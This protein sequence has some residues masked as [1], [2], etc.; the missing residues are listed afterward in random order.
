MLVLYLCVLILFS[1]H[2]LSLNLILVDEPL[3]EVVL[4]EKSHVAA[5]E[6]LGR[7]LNPYSGHEWE[8]RSRHDLTQTG[9]HEWKMSSSGTG[10]MSNT[11]GN[12]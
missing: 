7:N 2:R 11:G 6:E 9:A 3:P 4:S 12:R 10:R 8:R 5:I 1:L